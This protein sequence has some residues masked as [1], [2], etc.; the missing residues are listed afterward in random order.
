[1]TFDIAINIFI[2]ACIGYITL[3]S[4]FRYHFSTDRIYFFGTG[5]ILIGCFWYRGTGQIFESI[6]TLGLILLL[7]IILKIISLKK[8]K[9]GY[10]LLNNYKKQ[11]QDTKNNLLELAIEL[12]IEKSNINYNIQ[13]PWLVIFKNTSFKKAS[14]VMNK[15][16]KI[17]T[18]KPFRFTM[19]NYWFIIIFLVVITIIWRF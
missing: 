6:L 7:I 12:E 10:F 4:I 1:M 5:L 11:Y 3:N 13:K 15:M 9:H 17:Y 19:Y 16:D 2:T 18:H 8:Q 14:K